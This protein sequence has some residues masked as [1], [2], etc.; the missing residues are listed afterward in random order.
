MIDIEL[1]QGA[2]AEDIRKCIEVLYSTRV[3]TAALDRDFGLSWDCM[4]MPAP[5]AKATLEAEIITKTRKY[6]PRAEVAEISW[7]AAADG[8]LKP[9]VVL[10]IVTN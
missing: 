10:K 5:A 1:E 8:S 3:G 9:K 7:Q 6:E 4:D 2:Q